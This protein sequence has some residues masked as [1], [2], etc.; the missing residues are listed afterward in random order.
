MKERTTIV[1][2]DQWT[3][4]IQKGSILIIYIFSNNFIYVDIFFVLFFFY[5]LITIKVNHFYKAST[6]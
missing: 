4:N 1:K 5:N 3:E 2:V 6:P